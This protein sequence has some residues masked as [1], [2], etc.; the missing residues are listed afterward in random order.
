MSLSPKKD[1]SPR[2]GS[3]TGKGSNFSSF[4]NFSNGTS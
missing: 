3:P 4:I 1:N 2:L